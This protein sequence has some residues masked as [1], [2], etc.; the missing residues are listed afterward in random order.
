[1][2]FTEQSFGQEIILPT[3]GARMKFAICNE[4]FG[5][6]PIEKGFQAAGQHG[7]T[8]L[9]VAPFTLGSSVF[10]ISDAQR[11]EYRE[12]AKQNG[13]EIIGLHWLLA[14]TTGYHLTTSDLSVRSRTSDYLCGLTQLCYDL[15]GKLMVLGS[16]LQRNFPNSMSH[17]EA[18]MNAADTLSGVVPTLE[19]YGVKI[20]IEPLGPQEGNFLNR[21]F[22]ARE[23]IKMV[24]SPAVQLHLDVKAMSSEGEPMDQII[25]DHADILLHFHANDPNLL[26]P[27]MGD[28]D[29]K[30]IFNA[31]RE[32]NYSGWVSV[33]VFDYSPG[34]ETI[35]SESMIN[36]LAAMATQ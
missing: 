34:V 23:L 35:L 19:K 30:P 24:G 10:E 9:E 4:T 16:P 14:K 12:V 11:T 2:G 5:D 17:D 3:E 33:E 28:V 13:L 25:R 29:Q 15:G 27:G 32:I 36:M 6:W 20:A 8:G 31:L 1:L 18:M 22:Q 7:Y 26:G 21:A